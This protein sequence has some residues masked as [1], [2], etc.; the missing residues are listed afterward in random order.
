VH[1]PRSSLE[2]ALGAKQLD[3][4]ARQ[5]YALG[6]SLAALFDITGAGDFLR[7]IHKLLDEWDAWAEQGAG[8]G[9]VI[10]PMVSAQ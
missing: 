1:V 10:G 4:L 9:T 3:T 7:A 8:K 2:S 5:E 6:L